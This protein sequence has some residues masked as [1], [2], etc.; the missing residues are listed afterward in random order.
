LKK[1]A[2]VPDF[3]L[4]FE[5]LAELVATDEGRHQLTVHVAAA[6]AA[7]LELDEIDELRRLSDEIR[8]PE[9]TSFTTT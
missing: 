6:P 1:G 5:K 8:E 2:Q 7:E 9:P 3:D 4:V